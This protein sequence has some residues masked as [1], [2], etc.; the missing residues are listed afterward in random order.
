MRK[1]HVDKLDL[2][3]LSKEELVALIKSFSQG[4][5]VVDGLWFQAVEKLMGTQKAIEMDKEVWSLGGVIE[6]KRLKRLMDISPNLDGLVKAFNFHLMFQVT[7]YEVSRPSKDVVVFTVTH[8]RPQMARIQKGQGEFACKEVG[9]PC[10]Q[11]FARGVHPDAQVK[12]L[13]C[14]PDPHTEKEWC[15]WEFRMPE[16]D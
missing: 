7:D 6:A 9:I 2:M 8:C 11:G 13:Q 15:K 4:T 14:P 10:M 3:D 16:K 12:C 1:G 5:Y